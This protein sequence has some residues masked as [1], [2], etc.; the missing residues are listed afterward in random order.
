MNDRQY[1]QFYNEQVKS[2]SLHGWFD[3]DLDMRLLYSKKTKV[4]SIAKEQ[5]S[6]DNNI[7]F[8]LVVPSISLKELIRMVQSKDKVKGKI[9]IGLDL[10]RITDLFDIPKKQYY[11]IPTEKPYFIFDIDTASTR[12]FTSERAWNTVIDKKDKRPLTTYEVLSFVLHT[13]ILQ[14]YNILSLGSRCNGSFQNI[15]GV[16][17]QR[18]EI[19]R[20]GEKE[21][22]LSEVT[23]SYYLKKKAL[24]RNW[25]SPFCSL[26]LPVQA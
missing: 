23:L 20:K 11:R 13:E 14:F 4:I 18:E 2:L 9:N 26:R 21:M 6:N 25:S 22:K 5:L 1:Q 3:N 24:S 17:C 7:A 8:L 16:S 12:G 15:P 19:W 10:S